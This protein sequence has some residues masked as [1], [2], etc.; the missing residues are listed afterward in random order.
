V[1]PFLVSMTA[2]SNPGLSRESPNKCGATL[3]FAGRSRRSAWG[4]ATAA[5]EYISVSRS[6]L[7]EQQLALEAQERKRHPKRNTK[8]YR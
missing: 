2:F 6:E 4:A 5:G 3:C 1:P 8:N 7:Y